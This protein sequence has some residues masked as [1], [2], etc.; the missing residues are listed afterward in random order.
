MFREMLL[1][2]SFYA[3]SSPKTTLTNE[4]FTGSMQYKH[5]TFAI[6]E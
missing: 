3:E 2:E 1:A 6:I 5:L 4:G